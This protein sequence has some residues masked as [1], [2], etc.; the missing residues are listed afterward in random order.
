MKKTIRL[1]ERDLTRI[2]KRVINENNLLMEVS[3]KKIKNI[4]DKLDY[5]EDEDSGAPELE[6]PTEVVDELFELTNI[7]KKTLRKMIDYN[8]QVEEDWESGGAQIEIEGKNKLIDKI[9]N[10]CK[11]K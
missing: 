7:P 10:K 1:T 5:Y 8:I 6:D 3:K 9:Y 11:D 2:V 4:L